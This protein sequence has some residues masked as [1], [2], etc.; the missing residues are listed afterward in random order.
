[1]LVFYAAAV[2]LD[3]AVFWYV[4]FFVRRNGE[5]LAELVGGRWKSFREFLLDFA[6]ALPFWVAWAL[7]ALLVHRLLGPTAGRSIDVL[8]PRTAIEIGAWLLVC[9]GAG[10]FEETI[11]R[12]YLQKQLTAATGSAAVGQAIA[13]G[14]GHAYQGW[15]NR[16]DLRPGRALRSARARPPEH[17]AGDDRS[18]LVRRLQRTADAVPGAPALPLTPRAIRRW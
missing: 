18:R 14:I 6:I 13:F 2:F 17:E 11:F 15:K 10:F 3:G 12:G 16:R 9:L 4:V 1:M 7:T 5:T 8:L